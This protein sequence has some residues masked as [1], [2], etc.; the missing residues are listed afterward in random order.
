MSDIALQDLQIKV[1]YLEDALSQLSD[2][3]YEQQRELGDLKQKYANL[4]SRFRSLPSSD[5]GDHQPSDE[6]PPHY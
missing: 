1:A 2:E 5:D 6:R 4:V 3:F